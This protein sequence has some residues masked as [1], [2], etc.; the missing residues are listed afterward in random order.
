MNKELNS[1]FRCSSCGCCCPLFSTAN[2]RF[3]ATSVGNGNNNSSGKNQNLRV[4]WENGEIKRKLDWTTTKNTKTWCIPLKVWPDHHRQ[5]R[6]VPAPERLREM[7]RNLGRFRD[8][9]FRTGWHLWRKRKGSR[10]CTAHS[11]REMARQMKA[12]RYS[13]AFADEWTGSFCRWRHLTV[14][15]SNWPKNKSAFS[16]FWRGGQKN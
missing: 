11:Q 6:R 10:V 9:S 13:F 12:W 2:L 15:G 5:Q 8:S 3:P 4:N 1:N 14:M 16:V 7:L